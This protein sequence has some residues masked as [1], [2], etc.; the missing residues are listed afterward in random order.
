MRVGI[1]FQCAIGTDW[2]ARTRSGWMVYDGD[3]IGLCRMGHGIG[4]AG[5]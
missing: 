4:L 1:G 5:R 3:W 2:I